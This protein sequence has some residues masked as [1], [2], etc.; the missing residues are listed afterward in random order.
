MCKRIIAILLIACTLFASVACGKTICS[1][2]GCENEA[3][4]DTIF[5]EY[6]CSKHLANKKALELSK[7]I[8]ASVNV[9]YNICNEMGSDVVDAWRMGIYDEDKVL[10]QGVNYLAK[11]LS[12]SKEE[13][14]YS[15][16]YFTCTIFFGEEWTE[17]TAKDTKENFSL[18][19]ANAMF[20]LAD[21]TLYD[22]F[23]FCVLIVQD[24]YELNGSIEEARASLNIAKEQLQVLAE[25][26]PDFDQYSVLKDYYL[27]TSEFLE[28]CIETN[29]AFEHVQTT[30][31]NYKDQAR[32]YINEL[33]FTMATK[34]ESTEAPIIETT[35]S[36]ET[37]PQKTTTES[38]GLKFTLNND[39]KSY[40]VTGIGTCNDKELVIPSMYNSLPVTSIG[41]RA[42]YKCTSLT[43][44]TIPDDVTSI[45]NDAFGECSSLT[46]INIPNSVTSIGEGTFQCCESLTSVTIPNSVTSIGW[47]AFYDCRSLTSV[48]ISDRVKNIHKY[49]FYGCRSLTSVTI[50][51]S[52]TSIG[53][54][55]FFCAGLTSV[56][57][58]DSVTSIDRNAFGSC[59]NLTSIT[60]PS[61]VTSMGDLA[62][63][64]SL[65]DI[66]YT[67]TKA[68]WQA[69]TKYCLLLLE[70]TTIH[71]NSNN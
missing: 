46:R 44:V 67:G 9:A 21:G 52:V 59:S 66:Y 41:E 39:G 29:G 6:Y 14:V 51:D 18:E 65:K 50:P 22:M 5:E 32:K 27:L 56:T 16:G 8:Y 63:F 35:I 17:E 47:G 48:T 33:E 4:E 2:E 54:N 71:Y 57:I 20:T 55:A 28:F 43:S 1:I 69:L 68:E 24:A 11:E 12:L 30:V 23:Q 25:R 61:S 53:E 36:P 34:A 42:F 49:T 19:T 26:Y 10:K 31:N 45:G 40:S 13:L 58:P 60:I 37:T 70:N 64:K 3:V 62:L 38:Q 7:E 15:V